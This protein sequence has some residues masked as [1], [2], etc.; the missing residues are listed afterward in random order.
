[1]IRFECDYLEGAHPKIIEALTKTNLEQTPGYGMDKHCE[2][3][4]SLIRQACNAPTADVHFLVGGTQTNAVVISSIL[5]PHQGV[6]CADTGH[7]NVHETGAI[8]AVGHKV[9]PLKSTDGKLSA[10]QIEALIQAHFNDADHEHIV[11]PGMVYLSQPT[12]NG[13]LY[14]KEELTK[15]SLTCRAH[16]LPLYVDG[17]RLGYGLASPAN[18]ISLPDL[19]SLCDAFYIGG[20]KVGA[21]LGEAVVL[22]NPA[23]KQDFRYL[24]KQKGGMLAKGRLLGIQF[25]TLFTDALYFEISKHAVS[26]ALTL[27]EAFVKKGIL[28][29]YDSFTNQ[30]FPI[31]EQ[32]KI[33]ILEKN[34]AFSLWSPLDGTRSALRF[35]TS[36]ATSKEHV[37]KL[38]RDIQML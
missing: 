27:K 8:E 9:L 35:C 29:Q 38:C 3:A 37:E 13:T 16:S 28:L 17:A 21:L 22:L 18:D 12:E 25:E 31:L 5:R 14:T 24:I 4:R 6:I 34:Y 11:Q 7:I 23:L 20:T 30:Q 36:W 32:D 26:L 1:M 15:I 10:S 2:N 19:A 33:R